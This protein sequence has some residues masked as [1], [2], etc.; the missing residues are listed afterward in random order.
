DISERFRNI[1]PL[2]TLEFEIPISSPVIGKSITETNFWQNT[3]A[4]IVAIK[5]SGKMMLSPGPYAILMALDIIIVTGDTG[6]LQ[7]IEALMAG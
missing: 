2:Y 3:G 4:T 5:R 7:R 6:I 1:N